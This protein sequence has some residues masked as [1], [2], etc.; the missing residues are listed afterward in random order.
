MPE[1]PHDVWTLIAGL[2]EVN[3]LLTLA[4]VNRSFYD[5]VLDARYGEIHWVKLDSYMLKTLIRLQDSLIARRVRRLHIR[6]WFIQYLVSRSTTSKASFLPDTLKQWTSD[7]VCTLSNRLAIVKKTLLPS[8]PKPRDRP[9]WFKPC[10]VTFSSEHRFRCTSRKAVANTPSS[11]LPLMLEAFTRMTNL[12]EYH[13]EWCDL[14][15]NTTTRSF[16]PD[17]TATL[18]SLRKLVLHAQ[19]PQFRYLLSQFM[20]ALSGLQ[21]LRLYFD[22][23]PL[24]T[25][26]P[27][28]A[29]ITRTLDLNHSILTN[30]IAPFVA[31]LRPSLSSL[32]IT[33][34]ANCDHSYLFNSLGTDPFP[35]LRAL[36]V[37]IPFDN[38][39]LS[40]TEG[41]VRLLHMHAPTLLHVELRPSGS[42][43]TALENGGPW[44]HMSRAC[45]SR[46]FPKTFTSL[47]SLTIPVLGLQ[48]TLGLVK[49][50]A[51]TLKTLCLLGK[52]LEEDEVREVVKVFNDVN[53]GRLRRLDVCVKR[54]TPDLLGLLS[55][56]LPAL[57]ALGLVLDKDAT[58]PGK[59]EVRQ[60]DW[61]LYDLSIYLG[62]G[63]RTVGAVPLADRL[64]NE[65]MRELVRY[66]PSVRSLKHQGDI[67]T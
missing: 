14:T 20:P 2:L 15:L 23:N 49:R 3:H 29:E 42:G 22:Y 64:E 41:L 63:R 38:D 61:G 36:A 21:D 35:C 1:L 66:I 48:F 34:S 30:T 44:S 58:M 60:Y 67:M 25:A 52:L 39:H 17:N 37:R 18:S 6:A 31:S 59:D 51:D 10:H 53:G 40:D 7:G 11:I 62:R 19:L 33:S 8:S 43:E 54:L 4:A 9:Q 16:L 55:A 50:S 45:L 5:I 24:S 65:M 28:P 57:W 12:T 32:T 13:F 27:T 46:T 47:E 56:G 26:V